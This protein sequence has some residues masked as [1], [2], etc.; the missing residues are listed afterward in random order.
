[1]AITSLSASARVGARSRGNRSVKPQA[2]LRRL[3][4]LCASVAIVCAALTPIE[5]GVVNVPPRVLAALPGL[6]ALMPAADATPFV[7]VSNTP[8]TALFGRLERFS[9]QLK[10]MPYARLTYVVV[11]P[12]G[13]KVRAHVR[14]DAKGY[15]SY[16]FRIAYR[17]RRARET[18][19]IGVETATGQFMAFSRFAVQGIT[20][21]R[22][23]P[24]VATPRLHGVR[25]ALASHAAKAAAHLGVPARP[26]TSLHAHVPFVARHDSPRPAP[27]PHT[28]AHKA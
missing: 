14:A 13:V 24:H 22:V 16:A 1:M 5:V 20:G 26:H 18:A 15:S 6:A 10:G 23:A 8:K 19:W 3:R 7:A 12:N 4:G 25:H 9:A 27:R 28:G 11:Y 21:P 17:P 2:G